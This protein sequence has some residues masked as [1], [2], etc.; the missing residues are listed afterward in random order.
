MVVDHILLSTSPGETRVAL[1]FEARLVEVLVE[2]VGAASLVGNIY[3]GRIATVNK[4]LDAAFVNFGTGRDGFLA[5]PEARHL[6][7]ST[8]S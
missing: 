7:G 2:R 8:N 1:M 6:D 5:L 4:G 3:L